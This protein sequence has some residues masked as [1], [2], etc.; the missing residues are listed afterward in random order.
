M[1]VWYLGPHLHTGRIRDALNLAR[2]LRHAQTPNPE[3]NILALSLPKLV[4]LHN[5]HPERLIVTLK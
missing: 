5:M 4:S 3:P 2:A 1:I